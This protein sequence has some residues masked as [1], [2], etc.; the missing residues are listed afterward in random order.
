MYVLH[1]TFHYVSI[2]TQ[3]ISGSS[4]YLPALHSTMFLLILEFNC[5]CN[6]CDI[7]TF[8]YV[9]INTVNLVHYNVNVINFTFHYVSI[10]TSI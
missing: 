2:N 4:R 10:N 1:F 7:F 9:S 3:T 5:R 6:S 8:H